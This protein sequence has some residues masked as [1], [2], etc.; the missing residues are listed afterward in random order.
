MIECLCQF[1]LLNL[2][3]NTAAQLCES[4][5]ERDASEDEELK[6]NTLYT[7]TNHWAAYTEFFEVMF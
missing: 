7:Y 3:R 6:K 4:D 2:H 5:I 1:V